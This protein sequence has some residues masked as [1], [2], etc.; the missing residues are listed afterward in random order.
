MRFSDLVSADVRPDRPRPAHRSPVD[1]AS[2]DFTLS[3]DLP[4]A[5][6][7]RS[8]TRRTARRRVKASRRNFLRGA[9][10][11]ASTGV[12]AS[13]ARIGPARHAQAQGT[14]SGSSPY[15]IWSTC[16]SYAAGH[17]CEPGCG[18]SAVCFDCCDAN[19]FFRNDEASGYK[20]LPGYCAYPGGEAEGWLW[21]Y[22][23]P[24]GSC[25]TIEY[26]CHD[27]LSLQPGVDG[28]LYW[29]PYICRS[30]TQC[31]TVPPEPAPTATAVAPPTPDPS[32]G[33]TFVGNIISA[34]D[35]GNGTISVTGWVAAQGATQTNYALTVDGNFVGFGF[36]G[37][38]FTTNFAGTGPNHGFST[39]LSVTPGPHEIC[40]YGDSNG[41]Q[42]F[43]TCVSV[44]SVVLVTP[45]P[46]PVV[47]ATAIPAT[48][49]PATAMP[50]T[51]IPATAIPATTVPIT[52]VP[53][54]SP[55][56]VPPTA[57]PP[58][59]VPT[60]TVA[61]TATPTSIATATPTVTPTAVPPTPV[62]TATPEPVVP[63]S[64]SLASGEAVPAFF[65]ASGVLEVLKIRQ[66]G[67]AYASGWGCDRNQN[68]SVL[69]VATVDGVEAAS[70]ATVWA[71]AD[72]SSNNPEYQD[73]RGFGLAIPVPLSGEGNVCVNLV[74]EKS[75]TH[76]T[77]GC[78]NF[79]ANTEL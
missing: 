33:Y 29:M 55:T 44:S 15:R 22:G 69:V 17:D 71:R 58:T 21:A 66:L 79:A 45:T 18:A 16:P 10:L 72:V 73:A 47:P 3:S 62:P 78:R 36:A 41:A 28:A 65:A 63:A 74:D 26:R 70:T 68:G 64:V 13:A 35:N 6:F 39:L 14:L 11:T 59:A 67:E 9:L 40:L 77:L 57:V 31:G 60:A 30:V 1:T 53:T 2:H 23:A 27:G 61:A 4:N 20:I 12:A 46:A 51:A 34:V 7:L 25:Q 49:V 43:I 32:Q 56:A 38:P 50:A 52:A 42:T 8:L 19:G 54:V 37:E 5:G 48:A 76:F 24:C 75:G